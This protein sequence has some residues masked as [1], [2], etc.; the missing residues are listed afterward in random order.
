[1]FCRSHFCFNGSKPFIHFYIYPNSFYCLCVEFFYTI[2]KNIHEPSHPI[3]LYGYAECSL[4]FGILFQDKLTS[5]KLVLNKFSCLSS[6]MVRSQGFCEVQ[7]IL[8]HSLQFRRH[9]CDSH[10]F[11]SF[12][13]SK[14]WYGL[15]WLIMITNLLQSSKQ[16]LTCCWCWSVSGTLVP[17]KSCFSTPRQ[18]FVGAFCSGLG[19]LKPC[20]A[21]P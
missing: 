6:T 11:C 12:L 4:H 17:I 10:L 3:F 20:F 16:G 15:F 8:V 13:S 1:M 19:Y 5:V 14:V 9:L 18:S 21:K 7:T 2:Q